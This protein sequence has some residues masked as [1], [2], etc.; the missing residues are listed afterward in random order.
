MHSYEKLILENKAWALD[1]EERDPNYF[2]RLARG[3]TPEFL[4]IGCADSRVP[5]DIIVNAEPGQIFSH[6][7]IANQVVASDVNCLSVIQYAVDVLEVKDIIVCGHYNCGGV[8][9]ALQEAHPQFPALNEWLL[10]VR[11]VYRAHR[12]ELDAIASAD[13]R[14]NRLVQINV[15]EQVKRLSQTSIVQSA[16]KKRGRPFIHGW[17]FGLEDGLLRQ[18]IT[19]KPDAIGE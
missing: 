18:L 15:V 4:W 5:G 14:A 16:W 11:E 1:V 2:Q 9:A 19:L 6:R 10:H 17:V 3:Q 7:N 13:E 8:K 12:D